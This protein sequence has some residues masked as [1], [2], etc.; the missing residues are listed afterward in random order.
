[1]R[2]NMVKVITSAS[3]LTAFNSALMIVF[4]PVSK[5]RNYSSCLAWHQ[6]LQKDIKYNTYQIT[7]I[8]NVIWV[9][10]LLNS[11]HKKGRANIL[12]YCW[13]DVHFIIFVKFFPVHEKLVKHLT[14]TM[15]TSGILFR[16][17][18][19]FLKK[20][21]FIIAILDYKK[22]GV[23]IKVAIRDIPSP[24][25]FSIVFQLSNFCD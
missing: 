16:I 10:H 6:K 21:R 25:I 17:K 18:D 13:N 7:N 12:K 5:K 22:V 20:R 9:V 1:M 2:Q 3:C 19:I 4:K 15:K 14:A 8:I 23:N 24:F 11:D